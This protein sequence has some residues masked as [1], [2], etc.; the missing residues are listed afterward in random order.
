MHRKGKKKEEREAVLFRGAADRRAVASWRAAR[1]AQPCARFT[2][3]RGGRPIFGGGGNSREMIR[4]IR[5]L[6]VG[7]FL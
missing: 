4:R 6:F 1:K 7:Y 2:G 3:R 5:L